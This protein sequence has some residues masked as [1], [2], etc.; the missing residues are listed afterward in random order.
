MDFS[1]ANSEQI[2]LYDY[3]T[4]EPINTDDDSNI[5]EWTIPYS[6]PFYIE[7]VPNDESYIMEFE[8]NN[9][10]STPVILEDENNADGSEDRYAYIVEASENQE[11]IYNG[12][13]D[14]MTGETRVDKFVISAFVGKNEQESSI[15]IKVPY[16]ATLSK[17][18]GTGTPI[19]ADGIISD[20]S[21]ESVSYDESITVSED[22]KQYTFDVNYNEFA[23]DGSTYT[24]NSSVTYYKVTAEDGKTETVYTV[25]IVPGVRNKKTTLEI[26]NSTDEL[27]DV[28]KDEL[29]EAFETSD[30]IYKEIMEKYGPFSA[31]IKELKGDTVDTYQSKWFDGAEGSDTKPS[32]YNLKSYEY[33]VSIDLPA[34]YTYD[35]IILSEEKDSY[36]TLKNSINGFDG[37]R[38]VLSSP[39]SQNL[40]IR[41]ILKRDV[42]DTVWGVQYIWNPYIANLN[43][44][45]YTQIQGGGVFNN[46]VYS[47][48][49]DG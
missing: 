46:H 40:N 42:S 43:E 47:I 48:T 14:V 38:L 28:I 41:I 29:S 15:R 13:E 17:W 7:N 6:T 26:A 33:D 25:N 8:V 34:G 37:K 18:T 11:V 39:D 3:N 20:A 19:A 35:V 36:Q 10:Q 30:E 16:R 27:N 23:A 31:T 2:K 24:G 22:Y 4:G 21:W 32:V 12:Y 9:D 45:N 44:S 1:T 5:F 49:S